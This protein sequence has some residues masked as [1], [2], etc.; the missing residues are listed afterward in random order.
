MIKTWLGGVGVGGL[1]QLASLIASG[2]AVMLCL[3]VLEFEFLE[4]L[5][6]SALYV[7][8][9][10]ASSRYS[11]RV[12]RNVSVNVGAL[13][14]VTMSLAQVALLSKLIPLHTYAILVVI[15]SIITWASSSYIEGE[16]I[17][18]HALAPALT[19]S[20]ISA[21]Y[22]ELLKAEPALSAPIAYSLSALSV[23]VGADIAAAAPLYSRGSEVEVGGW[24]PLDSITLSPTISALLSMALACLQHGV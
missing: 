19:A 1:K 17:G 23:L 5:T 6:V 20:S 7:L 11:I 22:V 15:S 2:V 24:G 3:T 21:I 4:A 9:L 13:S 14:P 8:P 16:G 12:Y 10:A 18:V